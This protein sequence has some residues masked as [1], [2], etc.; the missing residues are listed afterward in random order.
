[1][2]E[3][4][5]LIILRALAT[6]AEALRKEVRALRVACGLPP[7][8]KPPKPVRATNLA[9]VIEEEGAEDALRIAAIVVER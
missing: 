7:D 4:S 9:Q 2:D 6:E 5:R 8:P 1:M 3:K